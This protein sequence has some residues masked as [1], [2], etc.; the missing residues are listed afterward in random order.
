MSFND[1]VSDLTDTEE[2]SGIASNSAPGVDQEVTFWY[3]NWKYPNTKSGWVKALTAFNRAAKNDKK[4]KLSRLTPTVAEDGKF[5]LMCKLC[6]QPCQLRN[7]SK[8]LKEHKCK[9]SSGMYAMVAI[10]VHEVAA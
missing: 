9:E 1:V 2:A 6:G 7:P 3:N 8:F 10:M 4:K 5:T